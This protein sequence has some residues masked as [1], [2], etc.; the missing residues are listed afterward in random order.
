MAVT[1]DKAPPF[2]TAHYTSVGWMF[3]MCCTVRKY[4]QDMTMTKEGG[5]TDPIQKV[6]KSFFKN[7]IWFLWES[8]P[9]RMTKMPKD[10]GF[11]LQ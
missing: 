4:A 10:L 6:F 5:G 1:V 3:K 8:K 11:L 2:L 9:N 7:L